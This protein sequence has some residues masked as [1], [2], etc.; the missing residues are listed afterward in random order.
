VS[1]PLVQAAIAESAVAPLGSLLGDRPGSLAPLLSGLAWTAAAKWST[2]AL[3][4]AS[5][6]V[7]VRFLSPSDYG[8]VGMATVFLGMATVLSECGLGATIVYL[9]R[10]TD[11]QIQQLNTLSVAFGAMTFAACCALATPVALFFKSPQLRPV[12]LVMSA[13]FVISSFQIVPYA[14]LQREKAFKCLAT[15]DGWRAITQ[16]AT[17]LALAALG[18]R[19]WSLVYGGLAG[20][21]VAAAFLVS[22]RPV[23]F[24]I[25]RS[26]SIR[27]AVAFS[28]DVIVSRVS[29]YLYAN[30][31]FTVA[32]RM[33]G[34][35]QLGA[36]TVAWTLANAP[37]DKLT[38]LISRVGPAVVSDAQHD[39]ASLRRYVRTLTEG[40]SLVTFPVTLGLALV[41]DD[42]VAVILGARW[43]A[44]AV[45]L[46][47]LALY[48]CVRSVTTLFAPIM[49]AVDLRWASRYGLIFP[50]VFPT[51]FYFGSRWGTAGIAGLWVVLY[52]LLYVPIYRRLFAK[53]HLHR[54]EYVRAIWPALSSSLCMLLVVQGAKA[55][56]PPAWPLSVRL[57]VEVMAGAATYGA[58]LGTAHRRRC[59]ALARVAREVR[60]GGAL[61]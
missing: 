55:C 38:D 27:S 49:N 22:R 11:E 50:V 46:R 52:P 31:D 18:W 58:V 21:G 45:P 51:A 61:R 5:T 43:T 47:W 4:W 48:A 9:R 39:P 37:I 60:S 16:T 42:F 36:Y 2:Q 54:R 59:A 8:L 41:A 25:P 28:R 29:W 35:A 15:A 6:L 26:R 7:V 56:L 40:I 24:R 20:T 34:Q 14:L 53:I 3:S 19:Y 30:S 12:I 32:G 13:A 17:T 57:S 10:L 33:L 44:V 23:V 1:A